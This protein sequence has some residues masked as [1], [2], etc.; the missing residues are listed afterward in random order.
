MGPTALLPLRRKL[1]YRFLSPLKIHRP[2]PGLNPQTLGPVAST[3]TTSPPTAT[4][5]CNLRVKFRTSLLFTET[6]NS[7]CKHSASLCNYLKITRVT[8]KVHAHKVH[9]HKAWFILLETFCV[10]TNILSSFAGDD[11]CIV[12]THVGRTQWSLK[13]FGGCIV[14]TDG[15]TERFEQ[16]PR[17]VTSV[18]ENRRFWCTK[19]RT[20]S[21]RTCRRDDYKLNILPNWHVNTVHRCYKCP[22]SYSVYTNTSNAARYIKRLLIPS[23]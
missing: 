21:I 22:N 8:V 23:I 9:A 1:C 2:R 20:S 11:V 17:R 4:Q 6:T 13:A 12:E 16:A 15:R 14:V 7:E 3:L 10:I 18:H 5:F 19:F